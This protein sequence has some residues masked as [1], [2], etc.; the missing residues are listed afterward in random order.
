MICPTRSVCSDVRHTREASSA[1]VGLVTRQ[2]VLEL[3][4]LDR[5]LITPLANG[6][7]WKKYVA[8]GAR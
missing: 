7:C 2:G 6:S 3:T 4:S 1:S 8:S 5:M